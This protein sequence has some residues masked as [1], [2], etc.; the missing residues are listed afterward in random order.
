M[1]F[2]Y[3]GFGT[4]FVAIASLAA[5][6][7]YH[8]KKLNWKKREQRAKPAYRIFSET[9]EVTEP[10]DVI[11]NDEDLQLDNKGDKIKKYLEKKDL[12]AANADLEQPYFLEDELSATH[13]I[14]ENEGKAIID[15]NKI[16]HT[17]KSIEEN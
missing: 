16:W 10:E 6:C 13:Q 3:L 8:L 5:V 7:Y 9:E 17:S 1:E 4:L 11:F 14:I 12:E 15:R 2:L